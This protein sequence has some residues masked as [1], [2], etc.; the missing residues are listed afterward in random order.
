[1]NRQGV[2]A[3][4]S[5]YE[6]VGVA[7]G[8]MG[9]KISAKILDNGDVQLDLSALTERSLK[10]LSDLLRDRDA[11]EVKQKVDALISNNTGRQEE[12]IAI[13]MSAILADP[14]VGKGVLFHY[15][16]DRAKVAN[17]AL[18]EL[19]QMF[20]QEQG[21]EVSDEQLISSL[22]PGLFTRS[23]SMNRGV[24][25][26]ILAEHLNRWSGVSDAI[27]RSANKSN[28]YVVSSW[29]EDIERALEQGR[30][31]KHD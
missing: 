23:F 26:L 14:V 27:R 21:N 13:L 30:T 28:S 24:L 19:K 3:A 18:Y 2:S 22:I 10:K 9:A 5:F 16:R 20:L 1:M 15:P 29:R 4:S 12:R 6:G 11:G 31:S 25:L 7:F 17:W 8:A